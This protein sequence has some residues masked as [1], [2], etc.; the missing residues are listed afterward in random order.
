MTGAVLAAIYII[1]LAFFLGLDII[2]KVPATLYALVLAG[3][4]A[5]AAVSIVGALALLTP[6]ALGAPAI[7]A[8]LGLGAAAA[9]GVGGTLALGRMMAAFAKKKAHAPAGQRQ[10]DGAAP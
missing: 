2:N 8:R 9:A 4:G 6:G 7:A 5:L 1:A 10:K 3:L